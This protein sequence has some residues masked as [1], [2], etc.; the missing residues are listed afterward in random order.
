MLM[1]QSLLVQQGWLEQQG[2]LQVQQVLAAGLCGSN[3]KV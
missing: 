1:V 2:W 3:D